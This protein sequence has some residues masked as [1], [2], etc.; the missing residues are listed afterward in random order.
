MA[1]FSIVLTTTDRPSLLPAA[2][3]AVLD[4]KFDD[5]ELI[6]SDN[7]SRIPA[8][9]VLADIRD[10][11]LRLIRTDCRLNAPDHWE[12][13][14]EHVRG[15]YVIYLGDDNALHPEIL[16][17][18][19]RSL[20]DH[21]LEILLWRACTYYHPGWDVVFG[22]LPN[23]GNILGFDVGSTGKL[24]RCYPKAVLE[25]FCRELR[26]YACYPN[27][28]NFVFKKSLAE[29]VRRRLGRIFWEP[30]PDVSMGYLMFGL[31]RD[32]GC[33]FFDSFGAIGGR[34]NDSNLASLL[35]RGKASRRVYD[36][37]EEFRGRDLLPQHKPKFLAMSNGLAA[38]VS[39]AK[40][41]LPQYFE[42]FDFDPVT[43]ARRTIEDMYVDRTVPWVEDSKFLDDVDQFIRGLPASSVVEVLAYR[44]ECQ[45]RM[46]AAEKTGAGGVKTTAGATYLPRLSLIEFLRKATPEQR[47]S[48]WRLWRNTG[49]N[50]L[51][52]YWI[53]G[54]TTYVDMGLYRGRDIADA[55]RQLPRALAALDHFN[56]AFASYYQQIG[57][58]SEI[59][60][61]H[62]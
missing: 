3:R 56:D 52:R 53:S 55:A 32:D 17:F 7:F 46:E 18:A 38:T 62:R 35:S 4:M 14:W 30:N 22:Q 1:R 50:P 51:G 6:V 23:K 36:Y 19:D 54:S 10:G 33:A 16:N 40:S 44:D 39:Q 27:M 42:K 13:A 48:A 20:R 11:R 28:L 9:E 45:A 2:V 29:E 60:S 34:S 47:A 5:L 43:L 26:F 15:D 12:F 21:D 49:R 41:L 25:Q 37:V 8:A 59:E 24:Y 58:I 61:R 57:Q 31:A